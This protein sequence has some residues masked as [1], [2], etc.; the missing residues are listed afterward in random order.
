IGQTLRTT[1]AEIYR[2]L[3][4]ATAFGARTILERLRAYG[5]NPERIVCAGG[6]AE[7]NPLLMQIYA[8]VTGCELLVARSQQA[9]ALGAA[10]GGRV[11]GGN[12]GDYTNGGRRRI[13]FEEAREDMVRA[14]VHSYRPDSESREVYNRIYALYVDLHD[15]FGGVREN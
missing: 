10:I 15:S 7:K 9:C 3:L 1:R 11:A 13:S 14:P 5:I 4:E 8:D 2:A 12:Y 6:I